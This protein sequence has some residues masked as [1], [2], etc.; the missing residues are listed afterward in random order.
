MGVYEEEY[1]SVG[2]IGIG[3]FGMCHNAWGIAFCDLVSWVMGDT[4]C[5]IAFI[6]CVYFSLHSEAI[7]LVLNLYEH[8]LFL[9]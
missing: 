3:I 5:G 2:G 7:D 4:V 1:I 9:G 6:D 8:T